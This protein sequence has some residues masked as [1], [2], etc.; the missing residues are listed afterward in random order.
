MPSHPLTGLSAF[1]L[2][3]MRRSGTHPSA[4]EHLDEEAVA[5]LVARAAEAGADSVTMLGSTGSYAYLDRA[6]RRRVVELAVAHAAGTPVL[7]GV[8]ALRTSAVL[9]HVRDAEEAGAAGVLLAPIT[10]QPLSAD[11]VFELF[12]TVCAHTELPVVLYDNPTTTGFR[13]TPALYGRIAALDGIASVKIPPLPADPVE[14]QDVVDAVRAAVPQ[15]V[16]VG[17][18]GDPSAARG[19]RAGCQAWFSVIGGVL[20]EAA[21]RLVRT[22]DDAHLA[23]LWP[24]FAEH[25]SLRV[26]AA[27]AEHLGLAPADCLPRPVQG[28][29]PN[30][31]HR[32]AEALEALTSQ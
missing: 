30:A 6:E 9:D 22:G 1:P 18:S 25:G 29:D 15:H 21:A 3:P 28:L 32:V 2:T 13:F 27:A 16:T 5:H 14:A 4:A 12:R 26:A 8:G 11:E 19:L 10:Y 7:A 23:P 31:R 17:I 20:P 24:L